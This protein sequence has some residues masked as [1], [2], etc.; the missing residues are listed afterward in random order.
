MLRLQI[1]HVD[2]YLQHHVDP[3]TP[4]EKI[5]LAMVELKKAGKINQLGLSECSARTLQR[6]H[7]V[8]PIAGVEIEFSPLALDIESSETNF[9]RTTRDLGVKIIPYSP[10]GRG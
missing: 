9:L 6:T 5:V 7:Q 4:I 10:P 8:H 3:R 1:N 2:M